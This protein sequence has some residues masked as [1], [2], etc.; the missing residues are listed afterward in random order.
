MRRRN[1]PVTFSMGAVTCIV[2]PYSAEQIVNMADELM[3]EVKNSTK[4]NVRF[5]TWGP[6]AYRR[7]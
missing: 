5:S 2:P 7:N 6:G 3:Y 1:L 4:D